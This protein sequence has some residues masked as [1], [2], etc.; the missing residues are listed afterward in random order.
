MIFIQKTSQPLTL[1]VK[2]ILPK[3]EVKKRVSIYDEKIIFVFILIF[4]ICEI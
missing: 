2:I 1:I 4:L 3:K